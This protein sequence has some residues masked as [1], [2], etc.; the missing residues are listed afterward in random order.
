M[1]DRAGRLAEQLGLQRVAVQ[2]YVSLL[3]A[4]RPL[5]LE[6]LAAA[7]RVSKSSASTHARELS[8]VGAVRKVWVAESR[9][10][11]YEIEDDLSRLMPAIDTALRRRFEAASDLLDLLGDEP[12]LLDQAS[13]QR[14]DRART[15][16]RTTER[17]VGDYVTKLRAN[18]I[19]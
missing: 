9:R 19:G 2:L 15:L 7:A 12:S 14:I 1:L 6:E 13:R 11:Y 18:G 16:L 10:D 5:D 4:G 3:L 8:R 17:V